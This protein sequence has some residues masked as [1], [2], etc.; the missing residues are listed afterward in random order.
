MGFTAQKKANGLLNL[1][2]C[3]EQL[4]FI[5]LCYQ[6]QE[7]QNASV[8]NE[9]G[10]G[11]TLGFYWNPDS[12]PPSWNIVRSGN[13]ICIAITGTTSWPEALGDL[14]GCIGMPYEG[15]FSTAHAFFYPNWLNI[16]TR[17]KRAMP[18]DVAN[19]R[20]LFTGHSYGAAVAFLG[21]L[22]FER[23]NIGSSREFLGFG[24]PKTFQTGFHETLPSIAS[25]LRVQG[26]IVPYLP[27][28]FAGQVS[29][30]L[31]LPQLA[32]GRNI[33]WEHSEK[34]FLLQSFGG[35]EELPQQIFEGVTV[36]ADFRVHLRRSSTRE[37]R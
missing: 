28:P 29:P 25:T 13:D 24:T 36:R 34:V 2:A 15:G 16:E 37:L 23:D 35:L 12:Y 11:T 1:S 14:L 20:I 6:N 21:A 30:V 33:T 17:I 10:G 32:L 9:L 5:A 31:N 18:A 4:A 19:C 8:L 26:D 27:T 3:L 7:A 22:A